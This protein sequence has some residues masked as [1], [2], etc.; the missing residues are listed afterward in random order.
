M[1]SPGGSWGV[2]RGGGLARGAQRLWQQGGALV[3]QRQ[4]QQQPY[5]SQELLPAAGHHWWHIDAR[6]SACLGSSQG[7]HM[8]WAVPAAGVQL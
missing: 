5:Q 2:S 6:C 1:S 4:Q 3:E 8:P 7:C